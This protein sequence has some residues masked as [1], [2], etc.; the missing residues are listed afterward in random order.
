MHPAL[1]LHVS[2]N[3]NFEM[4]SCWHVYLIFEQRLCFSV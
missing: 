3:R 2:K 4:Y 1:T